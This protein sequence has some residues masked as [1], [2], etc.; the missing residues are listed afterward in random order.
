MYLASYLIDLCEIIFDY[1]FIFNLI[2]FNNYK[3]NFNNIKLN[4][5][6]HYNFA[7]IYIF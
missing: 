3:F 7:D 1:K 6:V 4:K 2:K 5:L